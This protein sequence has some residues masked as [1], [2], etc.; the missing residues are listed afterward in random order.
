MSLSVSRFMDCWTPL[1]GQRISSQRNRLAALNGLLRISAEL[2]FARRVTLVRLRRDLGFSAH[3]LSAYT[4]AMVLTPNPPR[5][6]DPRVAR[7]LAVAVLCL[8][9]AIGIWGALQSGP[10]THR[11]ATAKQGNVEKKVTEPSDG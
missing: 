10:P 4:A 2:P 3:A 1:V 11:T 8:G 9:V 6:L 7:V 5:G